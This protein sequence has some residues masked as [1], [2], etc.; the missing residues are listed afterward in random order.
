MNGFSILEY[1]RTNLADAL[2]ERGDE[3]P[4]FALLRISPWVAMSLMQKGIRRGRT[5][6]ALG[7][8]ATLLEVSPQRLWRKLPHASD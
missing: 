7:A 5:D 1:Y 2:R 6:L 4:E 3:V 8:A